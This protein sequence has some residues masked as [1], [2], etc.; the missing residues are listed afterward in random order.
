MAAKE[1]TVRLWSTAQ[2]DLIKLQIRDDGDSLYD[3][4]CLVVLSE[5]IVFLN[6]IP[7][8]KFSSKGLG[9]E[10]FS[11]HEITRSVAALFLLQIYLKFRMVLKETSS[12][13]M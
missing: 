4:L 11:Y 3:F 7:R 2:T 9:Y 5:R 6:G 12:A 1:S 13:I 8:P 10:P